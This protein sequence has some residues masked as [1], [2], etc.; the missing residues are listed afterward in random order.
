MKKKYKTKRKLNSSNAQIINLDE[1]PNS[2]AIIYTFCPYVDTSGNVFAKRIQ[3]EIKERLTVITNK[4]VS[5]PPIDNTLTKLVEPY[6]YKRLEMQSTFTYRDWN[7]FNDFIDKA[8][9]A[10]LKEVDEGEEYK[11]LYSRS[12]SV[13]THL[14]AYKIKKHN[15]NIKWIAEFSDPIIKEVDGSERNVD[16]P[17]SW[18]KENGLDRIFSEYD[19]NKNLFFISELLVYLYADEI[20]FTNELQKEFMLSYLKDKFFN[21]NQH[22]ILIT[23]I[24]QKIIVKP[25]PTLER[26]FYNMGSVNINMNKKHI[27]IGYFGNFNMNRGISEFVS[28]WDSLEHNKK[29]KI[30]LYIFTNMNA[31]NIYKSI[32]NEIRDFI[33]IRKSLSYL[34]FLG[35]LD[36]FDF[37]LSLDTQA[38]KFLGINPFLPSK[39]SDYLGSN[40]KILA[41][42]EEGSPTDLLNYPNMIKQYMGKVDLNKIIIGE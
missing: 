19:N 15:P 10:Y 29:K 41:I 42:L 37:V 4:F 39:I 5:N 30:R 8:Y 12:M 11:N 18:L 25:H 40:A 1:L 9:E 32:P 13:I 17:I 16:I 33:E 3:S 38:T 23:S 6:V 27:N 22:N 28:S 7:H 34:D 24:N 35:V 14:V 2:L 31:D 36:S 20:I 21:I 26:K